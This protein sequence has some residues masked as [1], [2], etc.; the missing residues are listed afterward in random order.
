LTRKALSSPGAEGKKKIKEK[1]VEK[2]RK[3]RR[4]RRKQKRDRNNTNEGKRKRDRKRKRNKKTK[5]KKCPV[6]SP[7]CETHGAVCCEPSTACCLDSANRLTA[8][9]HSF[10]C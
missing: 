5:G 8:H 2:E 10:R 7:D 9:K 1:K 3:E 6:Q 4:K